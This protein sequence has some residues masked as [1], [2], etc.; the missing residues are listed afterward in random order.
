VCVCF[1]VWLLFL[2]VG[3]L[4]CCLGLLCERGPTERRLSCCL[5]SRFIVLLASITVWVVARLFEATAWLADLESTR[6]MTFLKA[7]GLRSNC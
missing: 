7:V 4:F 3:E 6:S 2:P 5:L 1:E